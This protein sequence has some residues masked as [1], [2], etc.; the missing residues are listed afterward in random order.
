VPPDALF[1]LREAAE[2]LSVSR[3][4]VR[5]WIRSGRLQA[6]RF[7]G[8]YRLTDAQISAGK[9]LALRGPGGGPGSGR[10][11]NGGELVAELEDAR[12]PL[13][14][15]VETAQ[16]LYSL[17]YRGFSL[18][19][20]MEGLLAESQAALVRAEKTHG[21]THFRDQRSTRVDG[22]TI[23]TP[24]PRRTLRPPVHI[25]IAEHARIIARRQAGETL[26]AIGA[27]YG[28]SRQ[29]I[30]Q[31]VERVK[32]SPTFADTVIAR[33]LV[34]SVRDDNDRPLL[35][36]LHQLD[37]LGQLQEKKNGHGGAQ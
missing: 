3:D 13:V 2:R 15:V 18:L 8:G 17:L 10:H 22:L 20:E 9:E 21:A 32:P 25:P 12:W 36:V 24:L 14:E 7:A 19:E 6:H 27:D 28:V 34:D 29:R 1:T 30:A 33:A 11:I 31:I 23:A 37:G 26:E 5:D 35:D 4:R 16:E